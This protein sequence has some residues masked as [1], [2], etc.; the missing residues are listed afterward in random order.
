ME[1]IF[2]VLCNVNDQPYY[3]DTSH[4]HRADAILSA[5]AEISALS[6][7]C[8]IEPPSVLFWVPSANSREITCEINGWTFTV[9]E[10]LFTDNPD[11]PY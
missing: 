3:L 5:E 11:L 6:E 7:E 8:E 4:E 10:F 9:I 2:V 1:H